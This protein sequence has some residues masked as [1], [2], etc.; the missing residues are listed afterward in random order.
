MNTSSLI[1]FENAPIIEA[2]IDARMVFFEPPKA[3]ALRAFAETLSGVDR[4][5]DVFSVEA[6]IDIVEDSPPSLEKT[7]LGVRLFLDS[8]HCAAHVR[9]DGVSFSKLKPYDTWE[10]LEVRFLELLELYRTAFGRARVHR[11]GVRYINQINLLDED[12]PETVLNSWPRLLAGETQRSPHNFSQ[13]FEF[14]GVQSSV[15]TRVIQIWDADKKR[16]IFDLDTFQEF[17]EEEMDHGLFHE[18]LDGLRQEKNKLF[19]GTIKDS[20]LRRFE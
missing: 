7:F 17:T 10:L 15:G 12:R 5:E 18:I 14:R 11:L 20:V 3:D 16:F 9:P 4:V 19:W 1:E 8:G 13:V 6:K 2:I